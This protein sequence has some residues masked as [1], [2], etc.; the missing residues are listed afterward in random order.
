MPGLQPY[1]VIQQ[2]VRVRQVFD[3]ICTDDEIRFEIGNCAEVAEV[4]VSL[5]VLIFQKTK[6]AVEFKTQGISV[7]EIPNQFE[8]RA[9]ADIQNIVVSESLRQISGIFIDLFLPLIR[10]VPVIVVVILG[11]GAV[12]PGNSKSSSHPWSPFSRC[13]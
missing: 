11:S 10:Q 9:T 3:D 12:G 13:P 1:Q 6:V 8:A 7:F 5:G 4:P 2:S